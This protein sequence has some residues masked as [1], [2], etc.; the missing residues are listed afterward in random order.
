MRLELLASLKRDGL[1]FSVNIRRNS[2]IEFFSPQI[3]NKKHGRQSVFF[4]VP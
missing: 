3:N 4:Y 1:G 2:Y